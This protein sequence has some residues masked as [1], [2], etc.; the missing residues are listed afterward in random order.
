[1]TATT[2]SARPAHIYRHQFTVKAPLAEVMAFHSKRSSFEAISPPGI[3]MRL[4]SAPETLGEGDEMRFTMWLGPI[5]VPWHARIENV[6]Q[7][8]GGGSFED[9][10]LSGPFKQWIHTHT[11]ESVDAETTI[12]HDQVASRLSRNP[13][14]W[15][16]GLGM[17]LGLPI[18][19]GF[20]GWKTR[21]IL[22]N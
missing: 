17:R 6:R 13:F 21:K 5:P 1:M 3:I 11:F 10:Q 22:E 18:L 4:H 15:A 20:R 2:T 8:A 16:V 12:V 19:F 7:T 14:W 9:R